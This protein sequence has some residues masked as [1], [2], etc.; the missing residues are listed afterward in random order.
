MGEVFEVRVY[1]LTKRKYGHLLDGVGASKSH[2]NRWNLHGERVIYAS[3]SRALALL[4]NRVHSPIGP[5]K[6]AI[7][8]VISIAVTFAEV[9]TLQ[10]SE[11][12]ADWR[13]NILVCQIRASRWYASE[14]HKRLLIVPSVI[15]PQEHNYVIR[16]GVAGVQVTDIEDVVFDPRLWEHERVDKGRVETLR[17]TL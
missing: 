17:R 16:A 3:S 11:L 14:V 5:P 4:E 9:R 15:V 7:I 13:D 12:T 6:D 10:P 2:R 1:R 8:S